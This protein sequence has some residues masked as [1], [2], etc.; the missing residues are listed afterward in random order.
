MRFIVD[1][2]AADEPAD[3][4]PVKSDALWLSTVRQSLEHLTDPRNVVIDDRP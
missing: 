2:P 1:I 3:P 4:D